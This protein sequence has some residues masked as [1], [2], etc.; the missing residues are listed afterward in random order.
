MDIYHIS[1]SA[2]DPLTPGL[3]FL[4]YLVF[5]YLL[6]NLIW[7]SHTNNLCSISV[8]ILLYNNLFFKILQHLYSLFFIYFFYFIFKLI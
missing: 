1:S 2:L 6:F 7:P 8:L 4:F 3:L 5:F